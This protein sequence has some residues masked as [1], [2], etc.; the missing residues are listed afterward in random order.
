M[1]DKVNGKKGRKERGQNGFGKD[2]LSLSDPA[3]AHNWSL[4]GGHEVAA[5]RTG[6]CLGF[7]DEHFPCAL[8][9]SQVFV[10]GEG[11]LAITSAHSHCGEKQQR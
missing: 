4:A 6:T 7:A 3:L 10:S 5:P 8:P 2:M 11:A 9:Q 1:K